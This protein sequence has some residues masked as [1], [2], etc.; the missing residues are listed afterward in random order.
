MVAGFISLVL[1]VSL[2]GA[3]NG[4]GVA[5]AGKVSM[6]CIA[7]EMLCWRRGLLF[8]QSHSTSEV[9]SKTPYL[10]CACGGRMYKLV[11]WKHTPHPGS[12]KWQVNVHSKAAWQE[13]ARGPP[14]LFHSVRK[15][16]AKLT[17]K[18]AYHDC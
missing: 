4:V 13:C 5:L 2:A 3:S 7:G 14:S 6:L 11:S 10:E 8:L 17:M 9:A 16:P 12:C 1:V 15:S 18:Y